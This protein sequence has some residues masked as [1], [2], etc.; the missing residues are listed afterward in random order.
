MLLL[1]ICLAILA[2]IVLLLGICAYIASSKLDKC[3]MQLDM[4]D[5]SI[6][7]L[8]HRVI[9]EQRAIKGIPSTVY[10]PD[11]RVG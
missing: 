8:N 3:M 2:C 11:E 6:R 1:Y 10:H 5:T 4:H 9:G 7:R